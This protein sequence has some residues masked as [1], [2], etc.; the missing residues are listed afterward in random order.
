MSLTQLSMR[1]RSQKESLVIVPRTIIPS[2]F[3]NYSRFLYAAQKATTIINSL[4]Q[5]LGFIPYFY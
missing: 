4:M 5:T 1:D 2:L 3:S